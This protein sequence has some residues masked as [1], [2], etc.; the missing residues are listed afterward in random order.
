M[1]SVLVPIPKSIIII[2]KPI[3]IPIFIP[4]SVTSGRG[5]STLVL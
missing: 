5:F 3:T 4:N 2:I 1:Y